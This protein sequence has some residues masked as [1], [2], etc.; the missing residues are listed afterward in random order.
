[1]RHG[2]KKWMGLGLLVGWG[3]AAWATPSTQ[4]WIPSTDIQPFLVPHLGVDCYLRSDG[5]A[6]SGNPNIFDIGPTIGILPFNKVQA[7]VG[8]DYITQGNDYDSYPLFFNAKIGIPESAFFT[9]APALAVGGYNFGTHYKTPR[10]DQNIIYGLAAKTLPAFAGL[11]SLGRLSAGYYTANDD[12]VQPDKEGMLLS[13][14]RM[15]NEI[16]DRLWA[17]VDYQSGDN[18]VGALSFGV[19]W[20]FTPKVS[21]LVGYDIYN[22]N[23]IAGSDTFTIQWDINLGNSVRAANTRRAERPTPRRNAFRRGA[24]RSDPIIFRAA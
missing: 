10:T 23:A 11:P 2:I 9:N 4:I 7:E 16:S 22:D 19:A 24:A 8:F 20:Y 13:W 6:N 14:D 12:V 21:L 15:M 3:T 18:G 1:M 17:A 5:R